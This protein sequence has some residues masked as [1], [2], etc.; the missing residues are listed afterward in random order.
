MR[1][2]ISQSN[3]LER[4]SM[5][6]NSSFCRNRTFLVIFF[7][8]TAVVF[9]GCGTSMLSSTGDFNSNGLPKQK[10]FVGGGLD[11]DWVAPQA[12]TA[13][14]VEET[15]GKII[16]TKSLEA[17]DTFD[18]STGSAEPEG[19]KEIFGVEMSKLKFSLYFIPKN[20]PASQ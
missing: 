4:E 11:I 7:V 10:Y 16:M 15:T 8:L 2:K 17:D 5:N 6:Q 20:V 3:L 12:G 9:A 14:L 18:F 19:A 13:Y 1:L